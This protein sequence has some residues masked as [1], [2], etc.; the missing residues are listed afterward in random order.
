[1]HRGVLLGVLALMVAGCAAAE[2]E[3]LP[4]WGLG[5]LGQSEAP[6]FRVRLGEW[7]V[8]LAARPN[9]NL[10]YRESWQE[11][12][13]SGS[14]PDSLRNV[15]DDDK[16]ESGW[17]RLDV[18]RN[19]KSW[20]KVD[21][22]LMLAFAYSWSDGKEEQRSWEEHNQGFYVWNRSVYSN[23]YQLILAFRPTWRIKPWV[24][25]ETE[26]G[27]RFDWFNFDR[28]TRRSRPNQEQDEL[29]FEQGH[30]KSFSSHG[31]SESSGIGLVSLV[32][33]L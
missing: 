32:F 25:L 31:W 27:V 30:G 18:A 17:V 26:F 20:S 29:E 11:N 4:R 24:S 2:T 22:P 33:W 16:I 23:S 7:Q 9:D 28:T 21:L 15:P 8:G 13:F 1:M 19:L 14:T 12:E 3:S 10:Y 5:W 6:T